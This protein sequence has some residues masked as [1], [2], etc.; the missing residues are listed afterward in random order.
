MRYVDDLGYREER[1]DIIVMEASSKKNNDSRDDTLKNVRSSICASFATPSSLLSFAVQS[2][3]T[4]ITLST[5][6]LDSENISGIVIEA[7]MFI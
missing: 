4:T 5:T 3:C 6:A 7:Y 1:S 2:I